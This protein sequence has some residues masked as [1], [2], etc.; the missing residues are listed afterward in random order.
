M[1]FAIVLTDSVRQRITEWRLSPGLQSEILER[2][3]EELAPN[4]KRHLKRLNEPADILEYSFCVQNQGVPAFDYLFCFSVAY[5]TDEETLII[6][7]CQFLK[8]EST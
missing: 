4:P 6:R 5:A 1:S 3:Y 2:L 8:I 7:D